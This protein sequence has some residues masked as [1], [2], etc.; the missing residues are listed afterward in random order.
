MLK[1]L[2]VVDSMKPMLI[3]CEDRMHLL[4]GTIIGFIFNHCCRRYP[5]ENGILLQLDT[6]VNF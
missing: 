4:E 3:C 2:S 6:Q 5:V 1:D